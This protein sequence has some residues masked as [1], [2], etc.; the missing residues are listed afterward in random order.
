MDGW[1]DRYNAIINIYI[2][3]Y[4]KTTI[5]KISPH[6]HSFEPLGRPGGPRKH[7]RFRSSGDQGPEHDW[8]TGPKTKKHQQRRG[9]HG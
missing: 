5:H 3:T 6:F 7:G 9:D 4:T 1:I 2:Y 8:G